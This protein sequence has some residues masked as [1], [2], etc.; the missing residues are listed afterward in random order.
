MKSGEVTMTFTASA[1]L[2]KE[3]VPDDGQCHESNG[4]DYHVKGHHDIDNQALCHDLTDQ[5][6]QGRQNAAVDSIVYEISSSL[7]FYLPLLASLVSG[8]CIKT[9]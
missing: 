7:C 1:V 8:V 4:A 5:N 6:R 9:L 2:G 3:P